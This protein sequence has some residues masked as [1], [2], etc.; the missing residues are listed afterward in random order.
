M[1]PSSPYVVPAGVA[2]EDEHLGTK[3]KFWFDDGE[4]GRRLF[5]RGRAGEDWS[6][7]VA[8]RLATRLGLPAARVDFARHRGRDGVVSSS[9]LE[10]GDQMA[11]GNEILWGVDPTYPQ[12]EIRKLRAYT[13]EA[14]LRALAAVDTGATVDGLEDGR[15]QWLGYLL[16]D[17]WIA[18]S[19]RHHENWAVVRRGA[20]T[21]L[22]PTYD[23]AASLGR[24]LPLDKV[25]RRL[26]G[27]D[28]RT[29]VESFCARARSAF[30]SEAREGILH[31]LEAFRAGA[32]LRPGGAEYW[33]E[34]LA[35]SKDGG[36]EVLAEVPNDRIEDER[37]EFAVR[38]LTCNRQRLLEVGRTD[39]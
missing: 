39:R 5:K 25:R 31:P 29:T 6:E 13:V 18:N 36:A 32:G 35:L 37:R 30:R 17:A 14:C 1:P 8:A 23:H 19:D 3:P 11:H 27:N 33:L 7:W 28:P 12:L 38:M 20:R 9:F 21:V 26:V 34:R 16:F 10:P 2:Q 15:D 24:N 4:Q 22:A